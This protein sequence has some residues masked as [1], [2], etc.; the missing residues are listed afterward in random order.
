MTQEIQEINTDFWLELF[1]LPTSFEDIVNTLSFEELKK[2]CDDRP[3]NLKNLVHKS[4]LQIEL[5]VEKPELRSSELG[6]F[7]ECAVRWLTRVVPFM[8]DPSVAENFKEFWWNGTA[9]RLT[10][11]LLRLLFC[12]KYTLPSHA[13]ELL[14]ESLKDTLW[15]SVVSM[16]SPDH[17]RRRAELL[18]LLLCL[19]SQELQQDAESLNS[20]ENWWR[21]LIC[22]K[23]LPGSAALSLSIIS[24]LGVYDKNGRSWLPYNDSWSSNELENLVT[25]GLQYLNTCLINTPNESMSVPEGLNDLGPN[26]YA[27]TLQGLPDL[28]VLASGLHSNFKQIVDAANTY[29]PGSMRPPAFTEELI[30]FCFR[31]LMIRPDIVAVLSQDNKANEITE[32]MIYII[33]TYKA[34]PMRFGLVQLAFF[35]IHTLSADREYSISLNTTYSKPAPF[36]IPV[37]TGS[38]A[39]VLFL[40]YTGLL[41]NMPPQLNHLQPTLLVSLANVSPF[42]RG[43]SPVTCARL[44][45]YFE[46]VSLT[47]WLF[48]APHN[49]YMLFYLFEIFNNQ[50]IY[51]WEGASSLVVN[52]LR[53]KDVISKLEALEVPEQTKE[54]AEWQPDAEWLTNWKEKLMFEPLN[55]LIRHIDPKIDAYCRENPGAS[56][57]DLE[58]I[59]KRS[60]LVGLLRQHQITVR[61]LEISK[62]MEVW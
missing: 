52:L 24:I 60:T 9:F 7:T 38:Y 33:M 43:L 13:P 25:V 55:A 36:D 20:K 18:K 19:M 50:L 46:L 28:S 17:W 6:K 51:Q 14:S 32:V 1:S 59:V 11:C 37:F 61:T 45:T 21:L 15:G 34:D 48:A 10:S 56:E 16:G 23:G 31:C 39:D 12:P 29:L 4:F 26:I 40:S 8:L 44:G 41:L 58:V 57:E 54:G 35:I 49:H 22:C 3:S 30:V 62:E 5:F 53:L 2:L 42:V 27:T 47:K